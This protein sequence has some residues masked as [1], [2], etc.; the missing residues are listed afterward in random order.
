M[1]KKLSPGA[2]LA[3]MLEGDK[4]ITKADFNKATV[5]Y[6]KANGC[7]CV[8]HEECTL[9]EGAP[10]GTKETLTEKNKT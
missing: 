10:A 9:H 2:M 4:S 1:S 7:N 6:F 8:I 3:K 5:D